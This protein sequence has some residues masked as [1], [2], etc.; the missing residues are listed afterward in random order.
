MIAHNVLP[1]IYQSVYNDFDVTLVFDIHSHT[2][3]NNILYPEC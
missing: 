1:E 2:T 3:G